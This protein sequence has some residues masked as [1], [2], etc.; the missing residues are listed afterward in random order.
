M[1][2]FNRLHIGIIILI[3]SVIPF[4]GF[5]QIA[6]R[7][8]ST[9]KAESHLKK[10]E[11]LV[12]GWRHV[13]RIRFDSLSIRSE[14]KLIQ[15]FFTSPLSYIPV[16][17]TEVA[18]V[19]NSVKKALGRKFRNYS[20]EIYT[21]HHLLRE[22]VPN[23]LRTTIPVDRTRISGEKSERIPV[24]SQMG[25]EKPLSGLYNNNIAMWDSHGWYYES[26]LDRWEWQRARLFGTVEDMST[27][28]FVLPYLVPMLE[29]SGASVFLPRE[30]DWQSHEVIVD[31][32]KSTAGS[33]LII[34]DGLEVDRS[35][36]G[37]LLKD[38]LI[39]GENPFQSGTSLRFRSSNDNNVIRY[40]P[41]FSEKGRYS[42]SVSYQ[43]Q[44]ESSPEV[45]YTVYHAGGKTDFLVNQKIGGGTWIYLGTFDFNSGKN[46][47]MGMVTMSCNSE[48]PGF[49]SAD[50]VKFG[51]GMGNIARRPADEMILNKKSLAEKN[52]ENESVKN[53]PQLFDYK[54]SGKPRYL[55]AARYYLQSAGFPDTLTY[56][57]NKNKNDYND[58]YQSRGAWV[59]YL[60]GKPNN[61]NNLHDITGLKI[62]VDLAF[63]FHTDAGV[64]PNDSIIGTLGIY[65]TTA[66]QG[67]FS[68]GK[69]RMASRDLS[70]IIQTQ[71]VDD[72]R[73]L[74]NPHWTRR[75][76]WDKQYSESY[77][78]NVPTML[79][80]LLSHQ[81]IA[82]MR[83]G[84]D[85]RF[86][87]D[88][89]RAI[90][91]G[92]LKF[93]SYQENRPSVVQPL[94][95]DHF[96]IERLGENSIKLSWSAVND[97]LE[98][99]AKPDKFKVYQRLDNNGFDNGVIVEDTVLVLK[100]GQFDRI[101]SFKVTA[102]NNGGESFP[103]ET[104]SV[105]LKSNS[106]GNIL[107]VNGFD[108]IC[109]PAIFDN[110]ITSGVA[111]WKDQG[112]ADRQDISFIGFQ[113]DFDR[114]S[115]WLDDDSPGWG[116]S[117]GDMEGKVI[118]G[119]SFDYPI[120]HGKAIM[121][122]GYSFA[123]VS[124]EV[125]CQSKYDISPYFATDLILGEERSTRSLRD[126]MII[127]YKIYT[128]ALM[129]KI[130]EVTKSGGKLFISG[131]YIGSEFGEINDTITAAFAKDV[132]HF[133]WRTG[134]ASKGDAFYTTDYAR[135][136][137]NGKWN[138]NAGY[139]PE[140][141]TVEAPD[142]IEPAGKNAI[143]AFRY[144]E[145]NLSA[146]IIFNGN[147]RVV[148]MGIPFESILN[149]TDRQ[150]LMQQI[151]NFFESK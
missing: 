124:D 35:V 116:A 111:W 36:K 121:A 86:R 99:S 18:N 53:D 146:G 31:N 46:P 48:K 70:D 97:Q 102:L 98:P 14:K 130:S 128:P 60:I 115:K 3:I 127:D 6:K 29:N 93:Q 144:G 90:Y 37:F 64:T 101:Y 81:N 125:F 141:Y 148:A 105:G 16:R 83:F 39:S 91:K 38:S 132:L 135:K 89:S 45:K 61:S 76:L 21:D 103:G 51:G 87:F 9:I 138:F 13:G 43:N 17:E 42:V 68:N 113:Y 117:Y 131:A 20:V 62:P 92:I 118:P 85:P 15:V 47:E 8:R 126:S 26:K 59:N 79:L 106:K 24:V 71:L 134:H 25:K 1:K 139:H 112:V 137:L 84:L 120:V 119:N 75:G 40:I 23:S 73:Q 82:D 2:K 10:L 147:Y 77:R 49:I 67:I 4:F 7:S 88:V 109:S 151:I 58:D 44:D 32:D 56:N 133:N 96:A 140:I 55:E 66:N 65:S 22:L 54:L 80:E 108:R 34:P 27:M 57:L 30:R 145:N 52:T 78:P 41:S 149:N 136:W 5:S 114:K 69:S 50:A 122:T 104:L 72:I 95:I 107:V 142:G 100:P 123:S 63:A 94:P 33:E 143:T 74:Y 129:S 28:S 19:E 150:S 11:N 110:G 12:P